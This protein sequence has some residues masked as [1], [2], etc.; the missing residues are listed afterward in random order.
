MAGE[1]VGVFSVADFHQGGGFRCFC[2]HVSMQDL[3]ETKNYCKHCK[4]TVKSALDCERC[5][6][7]F[8]PSCAHQ[9]R[10]A[11]KN[12][13][14]ICCDQNQKSEVGP[15]GGPVSSTKVVQSAAEMDDKQLKSIR[16][17]MDEI[18]NPFKTQMEKGM[19]E[20]KKSVQ[21]MSDAFEEQKRVCQEA[22]R[23][24]GV[25]KKENGELKQRVHLLETRLDVMEQRGKTNNMIIVGV[26][27]QGGSDANTVVRKICSAIQ[28]P[29][30]E[31]DI[32]ECFRLGK[33]DSERILVSFE[34]HE[35]KR[36][37]SKKI[38]ELKGITVRKCN[39]EG[40]DGRIY[41]NDDMTSMKR[42]LFKK[43]REIKTKKGYKAAYTLNGNIYI[44][45]REGDTPIKIKSEEDLQRII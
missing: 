8:H 21:Y 12:N 20:I 2:C 15:G 34:K 3:E 42:L 28:V 38:R 1:H 27:K 25:I 36:E 45:K 4:K 32:R 26:P 24:V 33:E 5:N 35:K 6:S 10:V 22:L 29:I 37:L 41:F 19:L 13:K 16:K 39:L 23:E 14:V 9:A 17:I 40:R 11:D 31:G 43:A 30:D 7:S 18:M 44:K